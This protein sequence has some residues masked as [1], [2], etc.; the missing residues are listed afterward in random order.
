[1]D[2]LIDRL[3]DSKVKPANASRVRRGI[4]SGVIITSM[5]AASTALF[6]GAVF[7]DTERVDNSEFTSGTVDITTSPATTI[8]ANPNLAP[9]DTVTGIVEITNSGSL[10]YR[11]SATNFASTSDDKALHTQLH[12]RVYE[13]RDASQCSE[14]GPAGGTPLGSKVGIS[15]SEEPLFGDRTQGGQEGDRVL[16]A[17]ASERLCVRVD[18]PLDT[19]NEFQDATTSLS[20]TFYAEQTANNA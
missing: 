1:M 16:A 7:T 20:F 15:T 11:Y 2:P 18:L 4:A 17:G 14:A 3:L 19:P 9:G 13:V 5:A 10:E 8:L 12:L 6:T